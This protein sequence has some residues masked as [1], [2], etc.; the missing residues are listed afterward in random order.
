MFMKYFKDAQQDI[1]ARN[2][3]Q[4]RLSFLSSKR[5]KFIFTFMLTLLLKS[6]IIYLKVWP[7]LDPYITIQWPVF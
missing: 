6:V 2:A 7:V 4:V 5:L 3:Q 1:P